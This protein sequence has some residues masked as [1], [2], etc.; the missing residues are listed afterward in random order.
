VR[1]CHINFAAGNLGGKDLRSGGGTRGL[2]TL[3]PDA[4]SDA[5]ALASRAVTGQGFRD[6]RAVLVRRCPSRSNPNMISVCLAAI[7]ASVMDGDTAGRGFLTT[8]GSRVVVE[9][10]QTTAPIAVDR[11]SSAIYAR[12]R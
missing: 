4:F 2:P 9:A 8:L 5:I 12:R 6:L 7:S 11:H 1:H 3:E 10:L